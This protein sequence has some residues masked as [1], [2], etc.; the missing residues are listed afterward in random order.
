MLGREL[1]MNTDHEVGGLKTPLDSSRFDI[2]LTED[3]I[4]NLIVFSVNSDCQMKLTYE[5]ARTLAIRI[6]SAANRAEI[7]SNLK[8]NSMK[9]SRTNEAE[10]RSGWFHQAF[11][12]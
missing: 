5:D 10:T 4:G 2:T 8:R 3:E 9:L 11:V 12:K 6:I 1:M 7:R